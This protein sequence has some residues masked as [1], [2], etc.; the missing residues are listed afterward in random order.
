[1][2]P[3][4]Q[5]GLYASFA[6]GVLALCVSG[7][8]TAFLGAHLLLICLVGLVAGALAGLVSLLWFAARH[9]AASSE[10]GL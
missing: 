2:T 7:A 3:D 10:N 4:L 1:M 5:I 6:V 8:I 9:V